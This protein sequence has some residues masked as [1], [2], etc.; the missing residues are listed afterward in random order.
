MY[1]GDGLAGGRRH[2][3]DLG[4]YLR[5]RLFQNDHGKDG[6]PCGNIARS[7]YYAVGRDHARACVALWRTERDSRL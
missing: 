5:Q 2:H 6:G 4:I 3:V 7:L 1:H